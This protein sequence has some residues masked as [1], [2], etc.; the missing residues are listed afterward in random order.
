M[1][2]NAWKWAAANNKLQKNEVNGAEYATLP[3]DTVR[4]KTHESTSTLSVKSHAFFEDRRFACPTL[5][6]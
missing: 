5:P 6:T 4:Q 3:V 1:I 2:E